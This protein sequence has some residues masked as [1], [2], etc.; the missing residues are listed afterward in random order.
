VVA[1][2]RLAGLCLV[3]VKPFFSGWPGSRIAGRPPWSR[4]FRS[5]PDEQVCLAVK[6]LTAKTLEGWAAPDT[7]EF[8]QGRRRGAITARGQ[9]GSRLPAVEPTFKFEI[10][11]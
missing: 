10:H 11:I 8:S 4:R 2:L 9:E 6:G 1:G 5:C 3:M 7:G